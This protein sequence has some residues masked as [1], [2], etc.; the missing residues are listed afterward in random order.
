[1]QTASSERLE[2]LS[3]NDC[4]A[5][6]RSHAI[7]RIA[8]AFEGQVEIF[9]VNYGIEGRII[10]FRTGVGTKLDAL[11]GRAVAFEIDGWEPDRGIGWSVVA[12]GG[13]EEITMNPGRA[14]EHLRWVPVEPSVPGDRLHWIGI[15]PSEV[16]GRRFRGDASAA[17]LT[18]RG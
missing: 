11:R 14:A 17:G 8:F 15:K 12:R 7:G 13:A 4:L 16:T 6:L 9:P 10:V 1:M 5:L 3:E 2:T 18:G